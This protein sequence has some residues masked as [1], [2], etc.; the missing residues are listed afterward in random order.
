[1]PGALLSADKLKSIMD[2]LDEVEKVE[3]DVRSEVSK[4]RPDT[5]GVEL[6]ILSVRCQS[7]GSS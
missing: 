1:M 6:K 5:L 4:V 3:D 2:F 7:N